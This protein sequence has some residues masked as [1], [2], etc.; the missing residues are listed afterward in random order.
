MSRR[1]PPQA[2]RSRP[3]PLIAA[4]APRP[5]AQVLLSAEK[6]SKRNHTQA[7]FDLNRRERLMRFRIPENRQ[8][9]PPADV[10]SELIASTPSAPM[11]SPDAPNAQYKK[12]G[13][14]GGLAM[15]T[16]SSYL[17]VDGASSRGAEVA[18]HPHAAVLTYEEI[19][20]YYTYDSKEARFVRR[21]SPP[22][23]EDLV[24]RLAVIRPSAGDL[25]YMRHR[26]LYECCKG[27]ESY[28]DLRTAHRHDPER[29]KR[30]PTFQLACI[31]EGLVADDSEWEHA[32]EDAAGLRCAA[33]L[34]SLFV[35]ILMNCEPQQADKLW[36]RF[37][38][39]LADDVAHE[40][41]R[42]DG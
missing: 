6:Q 17:H 11:Y 36:E 15:H 21:C 38:D 28:A 33:S 4:V 32:L 19:P 13:R 27:A 39:E 31:E 22:K 12:L 29:S 1:D 8:P 5:F 2:L 7:F 14:G 3:A 10:Q 18:F 37:K 16:V 23:A 25:F 35:E 40:N 42:P 24:T 41:Y 26:L 20:I 30:C 34:R 9:P